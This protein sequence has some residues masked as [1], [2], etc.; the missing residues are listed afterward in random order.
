L[1]AVAGYWI[2]FNAGDA[3]RRSLY[4]YP[5]WP[6]RPDHF[7]DLYSPW[8]D[9][10]WQPSPSESHLMTLGCAPYSRK[11]GV[12]ARRLAAPQAVQTVESEGPVL[13]PAGAWLCIGAKGSAWGTP[14]SMSDEAFCSRYLAAGMCEER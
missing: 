2:C 13:V 5:H 10:D 4:E 8:D 1:I 3:V 9:P 14:Y 6:V 7:Q 12:W 11:V